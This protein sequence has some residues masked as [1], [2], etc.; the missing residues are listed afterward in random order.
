MSEGLK[1]PWVQTLL[2]LRSFLGVALCKEHPLGEPKLFCLP[3]AQ[4]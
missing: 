3:A 2:L 4:S 1:A